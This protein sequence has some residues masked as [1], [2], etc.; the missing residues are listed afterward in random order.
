MVELTEGQ[1]TFA[2]WLVQICKE[3]K[4]NK[5]VILKPKNKIFNKVIYPDS[6]QTIGNPTDK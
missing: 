2:T 4:N 5:T 1:H 3:P 6:F